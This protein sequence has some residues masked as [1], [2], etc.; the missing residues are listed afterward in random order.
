MDRYLKESD[1]FHVPG[2]SGFETSAGG[3]EDRPQTRSQTA[4]YVGKTQNEEMRTSS[5]SHCEASSFTRPSSV[6]EEELG[7]GTR[8]QSGSLVNFHPTR[9]IDTS[10]DEGQTSRLHQPEGGQIH[11]MIV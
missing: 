7:R 5:F 10:D 11:N 2:R 8:A 9:Y 4:R 6:G 1:A 3:L